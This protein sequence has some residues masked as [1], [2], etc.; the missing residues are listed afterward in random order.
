MNSEELKAAYSQNGETQN[1]HLNRLAEEMHITAVTK[2]FWK[3][4]VYMDKVA[5]KLALVHSEVTEV[6]EA[7][8]KSQGLDKVTQEFADILIRTLSL[9]YKLVEDGLAAPGI[10][11]TV[12]MVMDRNNERPPM[13]GHKWG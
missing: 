9:Y 13:H 6:L 1:E 10:D 2:G 7:L 8:R 4:P 3:D 12:R 11:E 5:A